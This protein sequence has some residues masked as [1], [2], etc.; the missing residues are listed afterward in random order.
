[1]RV[2]GAFSESIVSFEI[3]FLNTHVL[4]THY[5]A[6]QCLVTHDLLVPLVPTH[7]T[8]QV[9]R[10][11]SCELRCSMFTNCREI[12]S[13]NQSWQTH[14]MWG[15]HSD[16]IKGIRGELNP[17]QDWK[18]VLWGL[19]LGFNTNGL[20]AK[21]KWNLLKLNLIKGVFA[22][23]STWVQSTPRH[24]AQNI[25]LMDAWANPPFMGLNP[26]RV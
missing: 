10:T 9:S 11:W 6:T 3:P 26:N 22:Q 7:K 2:H 19:G 21:W 8:R 12:G 17:S 13:F 16:S 24:G 18:V 5:L 1:M 15:M 4:V 14:V 25:G 23:G 20:W